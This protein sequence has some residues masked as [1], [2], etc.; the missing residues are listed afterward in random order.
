LTDRPQI[1]A[2]APLAAAVAKI[3]LRIE[4]T[5]RSYSFCYRTGDGDFKPLKQDVDGSFLSTEIA[6]G[7]QGVM[8]GMYARN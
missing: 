3:E 2:N 8:L 1:L 4:S 5:G 6:G 7:F